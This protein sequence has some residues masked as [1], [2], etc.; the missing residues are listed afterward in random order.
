MHRNLILATSLAAAALA[1][2]VCA[3]AQ[4]AP[5]QPLGLLVPDPVQPPAASARG[6]DPLSGISF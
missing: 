5:V 1:L 6:D 4:T 2:P 3:N